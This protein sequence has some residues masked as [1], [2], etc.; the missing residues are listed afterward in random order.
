MSLNF[1]VPCRIMA[2]SLLFGAGQRN[3]VIRRRKSMPSCTASSNVAHSSAV[4]GMPGVKI[5]RGERVA[6]FARRLAADWHNF[7]Q[8]QEN[9]QFWAHT[10]LTF[11]PL[12][13]S[14]LGGYAFYTESAYDYNLA[15][16]YKTAVT[17]IV[18]APST[19][20]DPNI[21]EVTSFKLSTPEKFW[22]GSHKPELLEGLTRDML[23]P[24]SEKCN[25]VIVYVEAEDKYIGIS[26]PGKGCVIRRGGTE[27]PTYFDSR[28]VL[29]RDSY[30]ALDVGRDLET[31]ERI[32]GGTFGAF[33]FVPKQRF[34]HLISDEFP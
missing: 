17:L 7:A 33:E 27:A 19:S 4:D 32:W 29:A 12:P 11:R 26:R 21:F 3:P 20:T 9:P 25:I 23:I 24:L 8:S 13:N 2:P 10:H 30:T 18:E 1:V 22:M 34:N 28:I 15:L 16:P 14:F 5:A 6:T 31:D